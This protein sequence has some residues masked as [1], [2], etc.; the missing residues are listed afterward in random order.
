MDGKRGWPQGVDQFPEMR[1]EGWIGVYQGCRTGP[2]AIVDDMEREVGEFD[3]AGKQCRILK[4]GSLGNC[5][6]IVKPEFRTERFR[7]QIEHQLIH[8]Q[9]ADWRF[10]NHGE[11]T[12]I[13]EAHGLAVANGVDRKNGTSRPLGV[14]K[15][16]LALWTRRIGVAVECNEGV[17]FD[18]GL[19][20]PPPWPSRQ[21]VY[22][23]E[24]SLEAVVRA[25]HAGGKL[26][27]E[28]PAT[29]LGQVCLGM[30]QKRGT[31]GRWR[32]GGPLDLLQTVE[33]Q[34]GGMQKHSDDAVLR[35]D[36]A[37]PIVGAFGLDRAFLRESLFGC[38]RI[39]CA[40]FH[41]NHEGKAESLGSRGRRGWGN[42]TDDGISD[43]GPRFGK[44]IA[45]SVIRK[46]DR[47]GERSSTEI[48]QSVSPSATFKVI[49]LAEDPGRD[50]VGLGNGTFSFEVTNDGLGDAGCLRRVRVVNDDHSNRVVL[51]DQQRHGRVTTRTL[52]RTWG[53]VIEADERKASVAEYAR[54]GERNRSS[55]V[56]QS[57]GDPSRPSMA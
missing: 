54:Q 30:A 41:G 21:S 43:F 46:E 7:K 8:G 17:A 1:R 50:G 27:Y 44:G 4:A 49:G 56:L 34:S 48:E 39:Q 31:L 12:T 16:P 3:R 33:D 24:I 5:A 47:H 52:A 19:E 45:Q 2:V 22:L 20:L 11:I 55:E 51:C 25:G 26:V 14:E 32:F 6:G 37:R 35:G 23:V 13:G 15:L 9:L 10:S 38:Q 40:A 28:R 42:R 18:R 57:A 53:T 29:L 36:T